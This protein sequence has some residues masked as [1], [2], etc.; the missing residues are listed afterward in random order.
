MILM[1]EIK[2]GLFSDSLLNEVFTAEATFLLPNTTR[3]QLKIPLVF[4]QEI[5]KNI[6]SFI[7]HSANNLIPKN[8]TRHLFFT[9]FAKVS[10]DSQKKKNKI[11]LCQ[12]KSRVFSLK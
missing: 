10:Q 12:A 2:T 4:A 5:I 3:I 6:Y 9:L 7:V 11:L 1:E 8:Q